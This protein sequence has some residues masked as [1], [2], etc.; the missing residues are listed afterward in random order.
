MNTKRWVSL[1]VPLCSLLLLVPF[2]V[3][4]DDDDDALKVLVRGATLHGSNGMYFDAQDRLHV[5]SVWGREIAVVNP[6]NGE[7]L[8]RIGPDRGVEGPDDLFVCA[9]GTIYQTSIVTGHV[10]RISPDGTVKR[11]FVAPGVNP[12]TFSDDGRLFVALD[13]F[14]DGL[15]EIDPE[16]NAPPRSIIA[17]NLGWMNGMDWGPDGRLYGPVMLRGVVASLDVDSCNASSDP[18][19]ECDLRVVTSGG[20]SAVKFDST[21]SLYAVEGEG[22][23]WRIDPVSGV[24]WLV[25]EVRG[26]LDNLAFDSS[27]NLYVSNFDDGFVW[28]IKPNG[29]AKTILDGGPIAPGGIAVVPRSDGKGGVKE[30]IFVA[31]IWRLREFAG[32]SGQELGEFGAGLAYRFTVSTDGEKLILS[33]WANSQVIFIDLATMETVETD[34]S[35]A[36]PLNA[37]PFAGDTIVAELRGGRV[38]RR[39]DHLALTTGLIVPTGLAGNDQDLY[40]A[41]WWTGVVWQ[42]V[43]DGAILTPRRFVAAG[44]ARPEGLA[45]D[46]D[47]TLLVVETGTGRLARI[48]PTTG[49]VSEVFSGLEVGLSA[50]TGFPPP[51]I[52]SGVAVGPTGTIYVTGDRGNVIYRYK[53][54]DD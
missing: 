17:G 34:R 31:D 8:D 25:S 38:V 27:D 35:F 30:S 51:Y 29:K 23:V 9:D 5:A 26:S 14:G 50:I 15:F 43:D 36:I 53:P 2:G 39:S 40:V 6:K 48:D 49:V 21:G 4:A 28:H 24:K 16:L 44:L 7:L 20:V 52:F 47:G 19:K 1:V 54:E 10:I 45:F 37:I 33:E 22:R 46:L 3:L 42:L 32:W 11:Q 12:I 13:F 18:W 41:D